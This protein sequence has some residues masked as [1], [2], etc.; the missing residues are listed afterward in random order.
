MST[1]QPIHPHTPDQI[2]TRPIY[3]SMS[4]QRL[5]FGAWVFDGNGHYKITRSVSEH[6]IIQEALAILERRHVR[7][8]DVLS[9]P[10]DVT[11][12]L[13]LRF[14]ALEHEVFVMVHL[15]N[16]HRVI[17]VD[18]LF[19]GTIDGCSVM[20]REVVKAA[21]AKNTA[22][23]V[24]AHNHPSGLAQ[25]SEADKALTRKLKDTLTV[26][27]IRCLDHVIVSPTETFSFAEAGL[28]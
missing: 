3:N 14:G 25:P 20:P 2:G 8:S 15:D 22:A 27:E 16:R 12:Y 18:E 24:L 28:L 11:D 17:A 13:R 19:R 26:V 1:S 9:S 7:E 4:Q 23:V 21:L 5:D 10:K 6:E